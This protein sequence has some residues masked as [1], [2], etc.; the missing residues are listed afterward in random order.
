MMLGSIQWN[1]SR[2]DGSYRPRQ[3]CPRRKSFAPQLVNKACQVCTQAAVFSRQAM[4]PSLE[5]DS[6]ALR[7]QDPNCRCYSQ[8]WQGARCS[9]SMLV[10]SPAL[11]RAS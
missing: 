10:S 11:Q 8:A 3:D 7:L 9:M 2:P 6:S 1:M 4:Q 5:S